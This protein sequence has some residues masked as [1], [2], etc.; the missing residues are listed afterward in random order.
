MILK[1]L[2]ARLLTALAQFETPSGQVITTWLKESRQAL[3]EECSTL[4]DETLLRQA[5]GRAQELG[6]L[7]SSIANASAYLERMKQTRKP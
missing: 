4:K 2:D 7:L 1:S 3:L 5:Q 6:E